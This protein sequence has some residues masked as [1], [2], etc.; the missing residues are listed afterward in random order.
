MTNFFKRSNKKHLESLQEVEDRLEHLQK[1]IDELSEMLQILQHDIKKAVSKVGIIRFN[2]FKEIGGDQSFTIGLLDKDDN[3][4][5]ITSHYGRDSNSVYAKPVKN[6][7]SPYSLSYE[8]QALLSRK[9]E[10]GSPA[11]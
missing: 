5:V 8:E 1:Q 3:G 10:N 7:S 9:P 11:S 4:V 2:P 6:G